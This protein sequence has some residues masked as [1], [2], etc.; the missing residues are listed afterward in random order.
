MV[1]TRRRS[2]HDEA[3]APPPTQ[4]E[5]TA[6]ACP[7]PFTERRPALEVPDPWTLGVPPVQASPAD[8]VDL[9][10]SQGPIGPAPFAARRAQA[11]VVSARSTWR[12][13]L[14]EMRRSLSRKFSLRDGSIALGA[15]CR[16]LLPALL[17]SLAAPQST[18][19]VADPAPPLFRLAC[20]QAGLRVL[21]VPLT[22]DHNHDPDAWLATIRTARPA[23]ALLGHPLNPSGKF[24]P[25]P[26]IRSILEAAA[27]CNTL[28]I[29]DETYAVYADTPDFPRLAPMLDDAPGLVIARSFSSLHGLDG[30]PAAYALGAP[31]LLAHA[32]PLLVGHEPGEVAALA[33]SATAEE[34]SFELMV[35]ERVARTRFLIAKAL[36]EWELRC[37]YGPGP[38]VMLHTP[39]STE[40]TQR[41]AA[42]GVRVRDL[43]TWGF[44]GW[45]RIR[46]GSESEAS[47]FLER[48]RPV[49]GRR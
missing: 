3:G 9:S 33:A 19:A 8:T 37:E 2:P 1:H 30:L 44:G 31:A 35:V 40:T 22:A 43:G 34:P 12:D 32:A 28:V 27:S 18:V 16:V 49:L 23:V 45:I 5:G 38:W 48:A 41:L 24:L 7:R 36:R 46:A 39:D 25:R 17:R 29:V 20:A 4:I 47:G 15:G 14:T 26:A 21:P 10:G 13:A 42:R 11:A 6:G